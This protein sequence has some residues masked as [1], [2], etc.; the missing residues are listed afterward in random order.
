MAKALYRPLGLLVSVLGGVVAG[1]AF[2]RLWQLLGH[3][4]EAPS[5]TDRDRR[6]GEILIA[7]A[8]EGAVFGLVK[9]AMERGGAKGFERATGAWPG[10]D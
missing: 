4:D 6:W 3:Q 9:A 2:K 8:L 10:D 7:A 1:V 5:A